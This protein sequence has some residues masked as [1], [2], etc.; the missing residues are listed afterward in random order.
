VFFEAGELVD[1]VGGGAELARRLA[2]TVGQLLPERESVE[3]IGSGGDLIVHLRTQGAE[4]GLRGSERG[5]LA[6]DLSAQARRQTIERIG[7]DYDDRDY[8]DDGS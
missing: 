2:H 1:I 7:R 3:E 4:L 5:P 6:I 8:Q